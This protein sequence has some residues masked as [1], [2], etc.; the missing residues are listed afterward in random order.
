[1]PIL[2]TRAHIFLAQDMGVAFL[3]GREEPGFDAIGAAKALSGDLIYS[4][5]VRAHRDRPT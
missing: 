2:P 1:M 4:G 3:S 5:Q